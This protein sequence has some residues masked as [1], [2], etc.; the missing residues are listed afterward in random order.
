MGKVQFNTSAVRDSAIA[1]TTIE[2]FYDQVQLVWDDWMGVSREIMP[3]IQLRIGHGVSGDGGIEEG[4]RRLCQG[5]VGTEEG[6]VY[7]M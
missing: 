4:W 6:L 7:T 2:D 1:Q 3:N 5:A